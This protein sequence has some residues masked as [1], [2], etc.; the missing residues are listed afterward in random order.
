MI[1]YRSGALAP[2]FHGLRRGAWTVPGAAVAL[3]LAGCTHLSVVPD[4]SVSRDPAMALSGAPYALPMLQYEVAV[5]RTLTACP[6][7][8]SIDGDPADGR[9]WRGAVAVELSAT[10]T[11]T[12]IAGERYLID[13]SKLDGALKTTNFAIEYQPGTE[14]LKGINVSVE[15][16]SGEVAGN[17]VKTG[18]AVV[19][20]ATG[21][22]GAAAIGTGV[23]T[24]VAGSSV[25]KGNYSKLFSQPLVER[26]D[27]L[28]AQQSL[29]DPQKA[30][31]E[32]LKQ[33]Q[34]E[35][36]A[37]RKRLVAI[38]DASAR[39]KTIMACTVAAATDVAARAK[40]AETLEDDTKSL[41]VANTA[42][43]T[44]TKISAVRGL[45]PDGRKKFGEVIDQAL[46]L[47]KKVDDG[48][49]ALAAIDKR[50]GL[51]GN[52]AW[53]GSFAERKTKALVPL[54]DNEKDKLAGLLAPAPVSVLVID[55]ETLAAKLAAVPKAE[56]EGYRTLAKDFIASYVNDD[57]TAKRF[58]KAMALAGCSS[59]VAV[60]LDAKTCMT[61]MTTLGAALEPVKTDFLPDCPIGKPECRSTLANTDSIEKKDFPR[62]VAGRSSAPQSGLFVRPPVRAQLTICRIA[63]AGETPTALGC[64]DSARNLVKDDKVLAA[65]LGQ[66]R[67][68]RLVNQMFSNNGMSLSLTKEGGIEKFQYASSKSIAQGISAAAADAAMQGAAF[69]KQRREEYLKNTDQTT[70]IQKQIALKE[71]MDKLEGLYADPSPDPA[72]AVALA[73]AQAEVE[74][75]RSQ[76]VYLNAQTTALMAAAVA[77]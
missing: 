48:Q 27:M 40:Q 72:K 31:R 64:A 33:A 32:A 7:P 8:V 14:I 60:P 10:A 1:I 70:L 15:D 37:M 13:Y 73:K 42:L 34:S 19:A 4:R 69:D 11:P 55:A 58:A 57:G 43:E 66:L 62:Q 35:Q 22:A 17:V 77:P 23:I 21:P 24:Q 59:D 26:L 51:A 68:F 50:L 61:S 29:E 30:F 53:P 65:Q 63:A 12:Q 41:K 52:G 49:A 36:E 3:A 5:T 16:H 44:L 45:T 28:I 74:L 39:P 38:V 18:L 76:I 6:E 25:N 46:A 56:L 47:E 67:Y 75:L 9:Y 54:S 71:A 20:I 2:I